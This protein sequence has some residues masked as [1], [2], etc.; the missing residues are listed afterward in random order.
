MSDVIRSAIDLLHAGDDDAPPPR[1]A[2]EGLRL[3]YGD[4]TVVHDVDLDVTPGALTV[5]VGANASGKSTLLRGLA[6]LLAPTAGRVTLDGADLS[7][8]P[9]RRVARTIGV[10][11]QSPIAPEGVRVAELVARGRYPHQGIFRGRRSDDDVI[12]AAALEATDASSLVDS[13]VDEL[14]GGQRQRVWIAMALAQQP[15]ILL[16]DEPTSALDVAHQVEVL[17]VLRA[18]VSRGMTVVLVIHDLTLAAR[19]ADE[20]VVMAGGRIIARGEP[21][22]VLTA[23]VVRQAFGIEARLLQDPDTGRPVILPRS[24]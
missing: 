15:R 12:V 16:L 18:E 1:L 21:G 23:E 22:A 7:R 8:L 10:L 11:P 3:G 5:V 19:Y 20:L 2:A 14:S 4:R 6:R 17:D 13:R 9:N 24:R